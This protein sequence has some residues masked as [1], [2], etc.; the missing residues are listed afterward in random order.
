MKY[1]A[2]IAGLPDLVFEEHKKVYTPAEFKEE[3]DQIL[4]FLDKQLVDKLFLRYDN[5]NL[6][7]YLKFG[8]EKM[9]FNEMAIFSR[10]DIVLMV[11]DVKDEDRKWNR[12]YPEYFRIFL[13]DYVKEEDKDENKD[14]FRED[15]LAGL[16]Y[17]YL[18][19]TRN[20]FVKEW[21]ELNVNLRNA[22]IA[23]SSRRNRTEYKHLIVG[24]NEVA[25]LLK[26]SINPN[27][28]EYIENYEYLH[29][30]DEMTDLINREQAIDQFL[31]DWIDEKN[32]F[33]YFDIENIIGYL[34]K[35]QIID[36]WKNLDKIK[37]AQRFKEIVH[38]LKKSIHVLEEF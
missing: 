34:I 7:S 23:L 14:I 24:D 9:S 12:K 27:L 35:L 15:R 30:I 36:R 37:G 38:N 28:S 26:N 10:E 31:W 20:R 19:K 25:Q 2:F 16:Y 8:E 6:L 1:Y 11:E 29:E 17:D 5:E 21:A 33:N 3:L 4:S 18:G 13:E 32:V 22:L